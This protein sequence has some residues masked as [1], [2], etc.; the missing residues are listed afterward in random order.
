MVN[1]YLRSISGANVTAKHFRTW[2][3][4]VLAAEVLA[5]L[6]VPDSER[7]AKSNELAALDL[8]AASLGNTRTVC[9]NCYVHPHIPASYRDGA[10]QD[11]WKKAR[12]SPR[13]GRAERA[14][15]SVLEARV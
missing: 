1:D 11:A 3:G 7:E 2:G 9:R 8:A 5:P 4:T 13:F 15:L 12:S 14:V 10:L 6:P